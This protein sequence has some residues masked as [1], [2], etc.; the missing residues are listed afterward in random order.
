LCI[1][2]ILEVVAA[3]SSSGTTVVTITVSLVVTKKVTERLA[4]AVIMGLGQC[5]GNSSGFTV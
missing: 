5:H 3:D 1:G 2:I 4:A